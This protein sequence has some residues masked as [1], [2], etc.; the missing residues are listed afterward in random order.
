MRGLGKEQGGGLVCYMPDVGLPPVPVCI[1]WCGH[2]GALCELRR[3][4]ELAGCYGEGLCHMI[5]VLL[6]AV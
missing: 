2:A 6:Q 3:Y 1:Q 4:D 5:R